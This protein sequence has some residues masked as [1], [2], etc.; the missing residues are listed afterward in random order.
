MLGLGLGWWVLKFR[1]VVDSKLV[2]RLEVPCGREAVAPLTAAK[3]LRLG[4]RVSE[5]IVACMV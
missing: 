4:R 1:L 2:L 5:R 3:D